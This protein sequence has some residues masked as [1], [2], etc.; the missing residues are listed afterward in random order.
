[1]AAKKR[2]QEDTGE[3][4][5]SP[6]VKVIKVEKTDITGDVVELIKVKVEDEEDMDIECLVEAN[7]DPKNDVVRKPAEPHV[8]NEAH[9]F[10]E[11]ERALRSLSGE[12][13]SAPDTE[14]D[15]SQGDDDVITGEMTQSENPSSCVLIKVVKKEKPDVI[16]VRM[17]KP[18]SL[19]TEGATDVSL[20][21]SASEEEML[22]KIEEQCATIQSQAGDTLTTQTGVTITKV[23]P[24][25]GSKVQTVTTTNIVP[26]PVT[27]VSNIANTR[28]VMDTMVPKEEEEDE[29]GQ[30]QVVAEWSGSSGETKSATAG[31]EKSTCTEEDVKPTLAPE[32]SKDKGE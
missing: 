1:M 20:D 6:P 11:A 28:V 31:T 5:D 15:N 2:K 21:K 12:V 29:D 18:N 27:L 23:D 8:N 17:E 9:C 3:D 10:K 4:V 13:E 30:F 24:S 25:Q 26:S 19:P 7:H 22:I 32:D 16:E 14:K